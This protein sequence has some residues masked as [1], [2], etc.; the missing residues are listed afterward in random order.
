MNELKMSYLG[1]SNLKEANKKIRYAWIAGIISGTMTLIAVIAAEIGTSISEIEVNLW[2]LF[3][4]ILFYGLALGI[5]LKSRV[6]ASILFAYFLLNQIFHWI[7]YPY[8]G[9]VILLVVLFF[10]YLFLEGMRGTWYYHKFVGTP[11]ANN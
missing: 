4:A 10:L 3:D 9:V 8:P 7:V 6:V 11:P 2:N 1:I 5:Y